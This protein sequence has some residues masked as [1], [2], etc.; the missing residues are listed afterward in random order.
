MA[1]ALVA[2][3]RVQEIWPSRDAMTDKYH[4]DFIAQVID[5]PDGVQ[6]GWWFDG[7]EWSA[8]RPASL[9]ESE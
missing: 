1:V 8:T 4:P 3:D 6:R 7:N 9:E 2:N 5:T